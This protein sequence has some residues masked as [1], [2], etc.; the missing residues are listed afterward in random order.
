MG[1][2]EKFAD[3]N[4]SDNL[5]AEFI[6]QGAMP[7]CFFLNEELLFSPPDG[8]ELYLT[9]HGAAIYVK[10]FP[11]IDYSLRL[12]AQKRFESVLLTVF[13][14]GE[15]QAAIQ[16]ETQLF[17][18]KLPKDFS[19]TE[20]EE[21]SGVFLLKSASALC[22]L[23][24]EAN[25]LLYKAYR[26]YTRTESGFSIIRPLFSGMNQAA[27]ESYRLENGKILQ[28][29]YTLLAEPK[30][31]GHLIAYAFFESLFIGGDYTS[32][33]S[34]ELKEKADDVKSFVGEFL[35]VVVTDDERKIGVVKKRRE[36]V[37][38]VVYYQVDVKNGK[39]T[40]IQT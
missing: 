2:F 11:P 10:D 35:S 16:S 9:M 26:A 12:I 40:D 32:F 14:Q 22:V 39:I 38:D 19:P 5:F 20:L 34:D 25:I 4:I 28:E 27:K 23:S 17:C 37:F 6:P 36:R 33:L 29:E 31:H 8:V 1:D 15:T 7:V 30:E 21:I 18:A 13:K 24:A 3:V